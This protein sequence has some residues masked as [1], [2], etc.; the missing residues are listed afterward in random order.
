MCNNLI[1]KLESGKKLSYNEYLYLIENRESVRDYANK[2]AFAIR[3]KYYGN[4][5]YIRGLIEF[6]NYCKNNCYYCGIRADNKNAERYRL[7]PDEIIECAKNGYSLGFRTFV[8]Q[9]GEDLYYSDEDFCFVIKEIK[10]EFPDCA[11]TL[12]LGEKSFESYKKMKSA[13][14]DRYLLRHETSNPAHYKKIHPREMSFE[15]RIE[16]LNNLKQL[17][18]QVGAGF[19]VGSPFQTNEDLA[20]ELIFLKNFNPQ[21]VGIGPFL[22]HKDTPFK[23]MEPGST[24]MTLFLISI[25][26][27][28]LPASLIPATT[29]L[30]TADPLGREKGILAGANVLMPNLSPVKARKKYIL[31][32]NKICTGDEAA[33]CISCLKQRIKKTGC[34]IVTDRGDYKNGI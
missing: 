8:L 3:Q 4:K 21:M 28:T 33:A 18:F 7:S 23:E 5:V 15:R 1:D 12:S 22:P 9:G 17:G 10:K 14:A 13:G 16:C 29:A 11:V 34:E 30:G 32:D 20:G 31:Y 6:S 2:K 26:R 19:M 25:I 27:L 24:E